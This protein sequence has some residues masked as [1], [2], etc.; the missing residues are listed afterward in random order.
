[1]KNSLSFSPKS[2]LI[3]PEYG[4]NIQNLVKHALTIDDREERTRCAYT[5]IRIMG[6]MFPY[7]RDIEGFKYK[8][9]DHLAIM[10]DFKLDID[11]PC[12]IV[13]KESARPK[14]EKIPYSQKSIRYRHYGKNIEKFIEAATQT[15]EPDDKEI[16]TQMICNYMKKSLIKWNKETATDIKVVNDVRE[17]SEGQL[18]IAEDAQFAR[19]EDYRRPKPQQQHRR[20][21]VVTQNFKKRQAQQ[22]R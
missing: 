21:R 14:P 3:L 18:D 4:R 5:I 20:Q 10:S 17:L 1:M 15:S 2:E 12:E 13:R 22:K 16:Q 9:W 11:Y 7:L 8:L 6:Q 19:A